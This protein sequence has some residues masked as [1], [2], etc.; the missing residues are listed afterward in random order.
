MLTVDYAGKFGRLGTIAVVTGRT[1]G[2][3]V[4][5]DRWVISCRAFARRI[6]QATLRLLFEELG[7][8]LVAGREAHSYDSFY[9]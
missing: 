9:C 3:A 1:A 6:E 7:A 5:V 4:A 2:E 8:G